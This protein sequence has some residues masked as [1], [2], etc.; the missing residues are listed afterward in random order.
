MMMYDAGTWAVKKA[1]VDLAE[2]SQDVKMD[3]WGQQAVHN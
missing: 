2:M 1:K 3:V